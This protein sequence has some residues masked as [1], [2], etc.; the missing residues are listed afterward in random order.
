MDEKGTIITVLGQIA[1]VEFQTDLP[2]IHDILLVEEDKETLSHRKSGGTIDTSA[3]QLEVWSSA[4]STS[5]YCIVLSPQNKLRRG[6]KV[7]NTKT[8][9]TIPSGTQV[10]GRALDIFGTPQDGGKPFDKKITHPIFTEELSYDEVVPPKK[11]LETGIK[12]LDFFSPLLKG[13]KAGIFGGAGVGKTILITEIIHNIVVRT[14]SEINPL[15]E[16]SKKTISVFTGVGERV[17]EGQELYETLKEGK[18]LP[19][20]VLLVGQMGEN[21]AV[22]FRTALGGVAVAEYFRDQEKKDVLF[23]IDNVFRFA[24]AGYELATLMNTI[25]GEG[26]YQATL[27]SEMGRFHERLV[28][29]K[30]AAVTSIEAIY[31]PS[32]DTADPAVQS[33]FP[34][35]DATVILSRARYQ[36]GRFPAVDM[37]SSTSSALNPKMVGETHYRVLLEA[38]NIMK[39]VVSLERIVSLIGEGELNPVDQLIYKRAQLL[40]AYM[41]Q[42]FFVTEAQTGRPGQ[43]VKLSDCIND[44]S[45]IVKGK[46]DMVAPERLMFIGS[47][48]DEKVLSG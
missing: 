36:E 7:I 46:F 19:E 28:S 24:Q 43:F 13:G 12:A 18:V 34:Y 27:S 40:K 3:T 6:M 42:S 44:V 26:G 31:V 21:P 25:P 2:A 14:N 17:R 15:N 47:L 33:I 16:G 45:D 11:V 37:L 8:S 32:D 48:K 23:F 9:L 4:S 10:L 5:F 22:R 20:V 29:T 35:L 38:Q 41:T 1:E 39:K 30:E